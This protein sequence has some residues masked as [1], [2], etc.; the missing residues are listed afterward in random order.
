MLAVPLEVVFLK[1]KFNR[2]TTKFLEKTILKITA[3][4]LVL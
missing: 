4:D 1:K 3:I 2:D